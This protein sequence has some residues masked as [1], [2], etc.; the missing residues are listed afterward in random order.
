M[1]HSKQVEKKNLEF[2]L[3]EV[4]V[5]ESVDESEENKGDGPACVLRKA[6]LAIYA[7]ED[8]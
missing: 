1:F 3:V 6:N 7:L 5:Q 8:E 4:V 2:T